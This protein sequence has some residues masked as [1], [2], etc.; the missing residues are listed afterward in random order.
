M[1]TVVDDHRDRHVFR[2]S[3][4]ISSGVYDRRLGTVELHF[5]DGAVVDY[6]DVPAS[7]WEQMKRAASPGKFLIDLERFPFRRR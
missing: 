4:R 6:Y 2:G 7:V 3:T 1:Q 5:P